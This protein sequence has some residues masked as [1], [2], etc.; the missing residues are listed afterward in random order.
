M[1]SLLKIY[2]WKISESL[3][4]FQNEEIKYF[5]MILNKELKY[6]ICRTFKI[7]FIY[8]KFTIVQST[9]L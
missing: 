2:V 1:E 5:Q 8:E 7:G 6:E 4:F 9:Y 3:F